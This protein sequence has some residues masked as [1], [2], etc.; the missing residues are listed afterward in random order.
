MLINS[1]VA[2]TGQ[3]ER[4]LH[5]AERETFVLLEQAACA[6][7][8]ELCKSQG[9]SIRQLALQYSLRNPKITTTLVGMTSVQEVQH[10]V[11]FLELLVTSSDIADER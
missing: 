6:Q 4:L 2:F 7:A 5:Y 1:T 3:K 11:T 8:T 10:T 9:K